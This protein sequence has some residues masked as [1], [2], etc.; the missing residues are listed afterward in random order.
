[1]SCN[2]DL[3]GNVIQPA[4]ASPKKDAKPIYAAPTADEPQVDARAIV[5]ERLKISPN[6]ISVYENYLSGPNANSIATADLNFIDN[7][8]DCKM[9]A[10]AV[11]T[12]KRATSLICY[13]TRK[14]NLIAEKDRIINEKINR[15]GCTTKRFADTQR[16]I[17]RN[18]NKIISQAKR[19]VSGYCD[20][21]GNWIDGKNIC[22]FITLTL[23][24]EQRHTDNEI[25][26]QLINPF[27]AWARK[28]KQV[29]YYIW[30]KELQAN[31]NIHFHIIWDKAVN[32]QHIRK[33][34]NS[35]CNKGLVDGIEQPFDYVDRYREKWSRVHANGFNR[36]YV[37]EYVATLPTT[38]IEVK[39][40]QD[41]WESQKG[42]E[43]TMAE[44]EKLREDIIT[45][46]VADYEN[47]YTKEMELSE[48]MAKRHKK[49]TPWSN[50]NS[51]D[52]RA[53]KSPRTVACYLAKYIAKDIE[54]NPALTD[55][56]NEIQEYKDAMKQWRKEAESLQKRGE[57]Y[58]FAM[59]L[60]QQNKDALDKYRSEKCPIQG[61]MW[62]KSQS[63]TV[64]LKGV[65][66]LDPDGK[67]RY[68]YYEQIDDD[69]IRELNDLEKYLLDQEKQINQQRAARAAEAAY[70]GDNELAEKLKKPIHLVLER[71]DIPM[72]NEEI[73]ERCAAAAANGNYALANRLKDSI[74]TAFD[75]IGATLQKSDLAR[76]AA[77][78]ASGGNAKLSD[79]Y[80]PPILQ[81]IE[82]FSKTICK[83]FVISIFDLQQL[84]T[85]D[86]KQR[87]LSLTLAWNKH[88]RE[89][90]HFNE[91]LHLVDKDIQQAAFVAL[92]DRSTFTPYGNPHIYSVYDMPFEYVKIESGKY[93]VT[94]PDADFYLHCTVP[95][96]CAKGQAIANYLK[97]AITAAARNRRNGI[98]ADGDTQRL[99]EYLLTKIQ[100]QN[101]NYEAK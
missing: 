98:T 53:V 75:S 95:P 68:F 37:T 11:K 26:A 86:G 43:M 8:H 65:P 99:H 72:S 57:D 64:F 7:F 30:K 66:T 62:F 89:C 14:E 69:Y 94:L 70:R 32:W 91:K 51:T 84:K 15:C 40:Q 35:L 3:F 79:K 47:A 71:Y 23:P 22:T 5:E 45:Q 48:K 1:M 54:D 90:K 85:E 100:Q 63:L 42:R 31:G 25:T 82:Q 39:T 9:S 58:S 49:Y 88:I 17:N 12:I 77:D 67:K 46:I 6:T 76:A 16:D 93:N 13:I 101:G 28:Q 33:E 36:E 4:Q 44:Y 20:D 61:R 83:T 60:W 24:A 96:H 29:R 27:F 81:V 34:W 18:Y 92:A 80:A 74:L 10:S 52:I 55:Y 2:V 21:K 73:S 19:N 41:A 59:E 56:N 38:D 87:F 50:P 97:D 78:L